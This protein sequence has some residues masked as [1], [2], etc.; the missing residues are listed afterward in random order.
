MIIEPDYRGHRLEVHAVPVDGRWDAVVR[1]RRTLSEDKV[2]VE[3]V[4]CRKL[5]AELAETRAAIWAKRW[6]DVHG[7]DDPKPTSMLPCLG[8]GGLPWTA[9]CS[10]RRWLEV[11]VL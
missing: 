8:L 10:S 6:V 11:S 9:D 4:T 1:I 3:T 5:T 7:P 2:H